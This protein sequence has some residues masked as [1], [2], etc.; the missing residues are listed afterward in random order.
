MQTTLSKNT[1]SYWPDSL[2]DSG[3]THSAWVIWPGLFLLL[4]CI[5][6]SPVSLA[7]QRPNSSRTVSEPGERIYQEGLLPNGQAIQ[8]VTGSGTPLD[9]TQISCGGCHRRSGFG[10]SE[11]EVLIPPITGKLLFQPSF[12][13]RREITRSDISS[14]GIRPA[15]TDKSL[16]LAIRE[17]IDANGRPLDDLMPRFDLRDEE[18]DLLIAYLK[19]L[20]TDISPGVTAD[21]IHLATVVTPGVDADK[22]EA[23]LITLQK[24]FDD[25]NAGTRRETRRAEHA[26]WHKSWHYEAYR[27]FKLHTWELV[28]PANTW[29]MQLERH[30]RQQPVFALVNGIGAG[31]WRPIHQFCEDSEVPCL[32]PTTDVPVITEKDFYSLY[33]SKGIALDAAALAKYLYTRQNPVQSERIV[34]VFRAEGRGSVAADIFRTTLAS[35]GITD[36]HDH[37]VPLEDQITADFWTEL[38]QPENATRLVLWLDASDLK[39]VGALAVVQGKPGEIYLSSRM[40]DRD[41]HTIPLDLRDTVYLI[42]PFNLPESRDRKLLRLKAWARAKNLPLIDERVMGNAYFAAMMTANAI[43]SLR[44]NL[45][46]EYLIERIEHMVDNAVFHSVYPRLSLG[47]DQ[48][49]AAKGCHIT[50]PLNT[51]ADSQ[52][53]LVNDW[54]IPD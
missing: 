31:R 39:E 3:S 5:L 2:R 26:P 42:E 24:Y 54:I 49:F 52:L 4:S 23:M 34:Q 33:F 43:K 12:L 21:T 53:T 50:G 27:K 8:A 9:G 10:S 16:R 17:G 19:S 29:R 36:V 40:L 22:R 48:R 28:G 18:L 7:D 6:L 32:F 45:K 30:Y 15:Y 13:P 14:A 11:G 20:S 47:P 35:Y 37:K 46:R 1:T 38:L 44:A 41:T 51:E 25:L